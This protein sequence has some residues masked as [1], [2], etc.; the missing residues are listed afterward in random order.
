MPI[1]GNIVHINDMKDSIKTVLTGLK[2][3]II[4]CQLHFISAHNQLP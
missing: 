2:M 4:L 3:F 1:G